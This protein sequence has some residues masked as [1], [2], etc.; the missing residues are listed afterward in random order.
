MQDG[1]GEEGRESSIISMGYQEINF[2]KRKS[3]KGK[4][5]G[6]ESSIKMHS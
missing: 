5:E 3:N 4:G 6:R 2:F 1:R